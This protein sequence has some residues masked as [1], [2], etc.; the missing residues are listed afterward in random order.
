M[1]IHN[2]CSDFKLINQGSFSAN[3]KWNKRPDDEVDAVSMTSAI[4]TSS[5]AVFEGALT[6][7]LQKNPLKSDDQIE[8]TYALL[9]VAWKS[10]GY[11]KIC[12]R[13]CLIEYDK[14][15]KWDGYKSEDY[16]QRCASQLCAYTDP[17]K[18]TWLIHDGTVLMTRLELGFTQRDVVLNITISEGVKNDHARRPEWISTRR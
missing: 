2:Q 17:I 14:Q 1:S 13:A 5:E 3:I 6:Y 7:Q 11:R 15:I 4:L 8:S 12:A 16:Y 9:F 10:E 18:D